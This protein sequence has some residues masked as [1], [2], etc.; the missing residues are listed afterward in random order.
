MQC[1]IN[2]LGLKRV[3][4]LVSQCSLPQGWRGGEQ[5]V[6]RA[7]VQATGDLKKTEGKKRW[8]VSKYTL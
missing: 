7:K 1:S 6:N 8:G 5:N 4:F 3:Y 2:E